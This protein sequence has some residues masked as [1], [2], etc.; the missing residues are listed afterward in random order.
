MREEAQI[1]RGRVSIG[2]APSISTN[3]LPG[4]IAAYRIDYPGVTV[5]LHEDF[6]KGMYDRLRDE[7]TDFAIGP[8]LESLEDFNFE[9]ILSDPIVA[10]LPKDYPIGRRQTISLDEV[11]CQPL[12]TM[13]RGTAIR[14]VIEDG[15]QARGHLLSPRFEV[16]HQQTLFNMVEAGLGVTILPALSVPCGTGNSYIVARLVEPCVARKVAIITLKGRT[17]SPAARACA[18]LAIE[19]LRARNFQNGRV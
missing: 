2:S 16:V 11:A 4:I 1:R 19:R 3:F 18:D 9:D 14:A 15:F 7:D 10:I 8:K 17:L 12:L 13:P 5:T 6:A